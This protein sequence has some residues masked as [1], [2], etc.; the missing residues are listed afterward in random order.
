MPRKARDERLDNR[1]VRLKLAPRAEPY[2]RNIQEG[3]AVGY[4][5]L[6]GGKAGTWVARHYDPGEGRQY[7]AL[8]TADDMLDADGAGTLTFAQA[9]NKARDWF[10]EIERSAG[11]VVEPITVREA[12]A[13]Y[14]TSYRARGGKAEYDLSTTI[15]AHILPEL[16][17]KLVSR[18]TYSALSEWHRRL[19]SSP[20]RL[21][22][23]VT[24]K[25]PNV[26]KIDNNDENGRRAR[27]ST[28]NRV[29]SV[30]KAIL[31]LA[32][33]DG[34]APSDD[35]WRRVKPFNKVDVPRIRYLA[36][37]ESRRLVNGCPTDLRA[38][39]TAALLTGCRYAEL[40]ALCTSDFDPDTA[41]L[42]IRQ[43]K[44]GKARTVPLTDDAARF[45]TGTATGKAST[46]LLLPRE[47][48]ATWGKSHQFRPVREACAAAKIAPAIS[49]HIL[50]HT[51]ASR[52]ARQR[53]PM[54]VIA[55][56]LGNS[57]AICAKHYAHLSPGYVADTIRQYGGGMG[58]V[59]PAS[60]VQPLAPLVRA[61]AGGF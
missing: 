47:N 39:V 40:A 12:V 52:L 17:D 34:R 57:E 46:A 37:E 4:R 9:Q 18:L 28:A 25:K 20:A 8:G 27:R 42:H 7:R 33:R 35:A 43:S 31:N 55:S 49:F 24:A 26:R 6:P 32:F 41:T 54:A 2:W 13:A 16:G 59:A 56:A 61:R 50:R 51:F 21:R 36:D 60:N 48:G 11:R 23:K 3:R 53:V 58:I 5:R 30:F 45:F 22:T 14:L 19:A 29:L 10:K 44:V 15:D 38:L 1:T